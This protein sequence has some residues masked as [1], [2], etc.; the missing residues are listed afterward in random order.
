MGTEYAESG[1][2]WQGAFEELVA[3]LQRERGGVHASVMAKWLFVHAREGRVL[4]AVL[5]GGERAVFYSPN[6]RVLV[7]VPFDEHGVDRDSAT[8]LLDDLHEPASWVAAQKGTLA[9]VHPRYR[10]MAD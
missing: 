1:L 10:W 5:A 2:P 4:V 6:A 8:R 3:I 7:A 9:W